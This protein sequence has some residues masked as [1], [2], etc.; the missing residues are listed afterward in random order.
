MA[1]ENCGI[2]T[3]HI[4]PHLQASQP[5]PCVIDPPLRVLGRLVF[6]LLCALIVRQMTLWQRSAPD[7]LRFG[8]LC[9]VAVVALVWSR[10]ESLTLTSGPISALTGCALLAWVIGRSSGRP[11]DLFV[12]AAPAF[13]GIGLALV[14]SGFR[15]LLQYWR[16]AIV[17]GALAG[18][19]LFEVVTLDVAGLDITPATA[20]TSAYLLRLGGWDASAA[21]FMIR[22]PSVS[23][24]VA[25]GCSG[26]KTV[27]FLTGFAAIAL[28]LFPISGAGK[29]LT[30]LAGGA[31]IGFLVNAARVAMLGVIA[32]N[33]RAFKFWHIQQGAMFFELLAVA[34]F[35][36]F[37]YFLHPDQQRSP[38]DE[39]PRIQ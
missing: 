8:C 30:V 35:L 11:D 17:L 10:R 24:I 27:Y 31:L 36:A 19:S 2:R 5:D 15:G 23:I 20:Q 3:F 18:A 16:E 7:E 37:F 25:Q 29:K 33:P 14:A 39:R 38:P 34:A 26:L 13:W 28:L 22:L 9:L 4:P 12:T 1:P 6:L 32:A 21:D